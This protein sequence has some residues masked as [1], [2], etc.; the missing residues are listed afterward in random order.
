MYLY[1]CT[2]VIT[3]NDFPFLPW[4]RLIFERLVMS[5][6]F[7]F[8]FSL[9]PHLFKIFSPSLNFLSQSTFPQCL[10]FQSVSVSIVSVFR[11]TF[12]FLSYAQLTF[13]S[14]SLLCEVYPLSLSLLEG[15]ES[16]QSFIFHFL[17]ERIE[18]IYTICSENHLIEIL[19]LL[20][21]KPSHFPHRR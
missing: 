4:P 10:F 2:Y 16:I 13:I 11:C 21:I 6:F 9:M 18:A 14:Q 19:I 15:P 8:C 3:L 17:T 20:K 7:L 1:F 5:H 12:L